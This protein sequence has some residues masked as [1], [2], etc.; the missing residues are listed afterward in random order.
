MLSNETQDWLEHS[1]SVS[2]IVT[3]KTGVGKSTLINILVGHEVSKVGYTLGPQTTEVSSH[4]ISTSGVEL[5]IWD[6]PGLQ[7]GTDNEDKYIADMKTKCSGY[8]LVIYCTSMAESRFG[9]SDDVKAINALTNSF[10]ESLWE[11]AIFVLTRCNQVL[12]TKKDPDA[13]KRKVQLF[14]EIIPKVL[15]KCG[16]AESLANSVP[17]IPAGY[18][19]EDGSGR[20]LLPL[21]NDWLSNVWNISLL[22]MRESAQPAMVKANTYRIKKE[23]DVTEEDMKKPA[24][25]QPIVY[26]REA[27]LSYMGNTA[28]TPIMSVIGAVLGMSLGPAGTIV[29]TA[30]GT[31]VGMAITMAMTKRENK[32]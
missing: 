31:Y 10:G 30:A 16:V 6:T 3:G 25:Q 18:I 4:I 26:S 24:H 1:K 19:E 2:T 21:T 5:V 11:R 7:D 27:I 9:V 13:R 20:E 12:P 17:V 29:G 8:D 15:I 14:S 23:E 28:I 32:S 22:R